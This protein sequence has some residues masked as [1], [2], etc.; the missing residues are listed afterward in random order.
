MEQIKDYDRYVQLM[1]N[2]FYDKMFFV[3]KIFGEWQTMLDYGCADGFLTKLIAE[4]FPTKTII[5]Y[6]SDKHMINGNYSIGPLP[7]NVIFSTIPTK[8]DVLL[9][10]SVI[11]EIYSYEFKEGVDKFWDFV[12]NSGFK[13]IIIRDMIYDDNTFPG[14]S[15]EETASRVRTW[16]HQ[17]KCLGELQNFEEIYGNIKRGG[18]SLVHFMLKYMYIT[19]PNWKREISEDYL[20][21]SIRQLK[22]LI[23]KDKYW[24]VH[25]ESYS[26]PYLRH[27]W[28]QDFNIR[29][30]PH[31]H[32]KIIIE[33]I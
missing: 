17:N 21:C 13:K 29:Y 10:S 16:C 18:R 12:F 26:V 2:G 23:P 8:A 14:I 31:T 22:N 5:G 24:I 4:V 25:T 3:D 1:R 32:S 6:D 20:S 11:H 9:L 15:T 27:K 7:A 28:K 19:S 30:Y 33:Q